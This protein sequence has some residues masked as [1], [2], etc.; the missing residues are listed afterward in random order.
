MRKKPEELRSFRWFGPQTMRGFSHRSRLKQMGYAADDYAGK[1]VIAI[2][3]TWSD[4]NNCH[5]H[6]PQ[7][8]Q[9]IRGH[10]PPS[11]QN[12]PITE[13]RGD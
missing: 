11:A 1:P 12:I 3:N 7:R 8:V 6:F 9:E 5:T 4:L 13:V 2:L 10:L